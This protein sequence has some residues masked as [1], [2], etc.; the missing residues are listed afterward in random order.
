MSAESRRYDLERVIE[1]VRE[2]ENYKRVLLGDYSK[3]PSGNYITD[4]HGY[5]NNDIK[6]AIDFAK[7]ISVYKPT[8]R[9][10]WADFI[11]LLSFARY[12]VKM[13]EKTS[14]YIIS[15]NPNGKN[16]L[17]YTPYDDVYVEYDFR[18]KIFAITCPNL[19]MLDFDYKHDITLDSIKNMLNG[20]VRTG[21]AI[22]VDISFVIFPSDR[23][24]HVFCLSHSVWKNLLFAEFMTKMCNDPDYSAF[25]YAR[26]TSMRLSPKPDHQD[27]LVAWHQPYELADGEIPD[28]NFPSIRFKSL[29]LNRT[30][31]IKTFNPEDLDIIGTGFDHRAFKNI[32]QQYHLIKYFTAMSK[33]DR[34][35]IHCEIFDSYIKQEDSSMS[36]LRADVEYILTL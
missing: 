13:A 19:L 28:Q 18:S 16:F 33:D 35:F 9:G 1:E 7:L 36:K 5:F 30:I 2:Y 15:P 10:C 27:D 25:C 29:F 3:L 21:K 14:R 32:R 6:T 24:V 11:G 26:G 23:G 8:C 34:D 12:A 17:D 31:N 22:G 4:V 20:I